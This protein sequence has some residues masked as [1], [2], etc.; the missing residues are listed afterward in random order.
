[1]AEGSDDE[2][3]KTE[4]PSQKKIDDAI[5]RGDVVKSLEVSGFFVL[6]SCMVLVAFLAQGMGRDLARPLA[7]FLEH[8][9]E[10]PVDRRGL[11]GL[12]LEA[13]KIMAIVLALPALMFLVAGIAGNM[14]QHR[15]VWSGEQ[16][17]PKLS[18]ISPLAGFKRLFSSESLMNFAKGI[19][20]IGV[21][22]GAMWMAVKPE[23][24]RLEDIVATDL[25]GLLAIT[26]HL[27]VKVMIAVL[28]VMAFVAGLD[29]FWQRRRW[30]H[31]LRMTKQEVKD[32][33]KQQ[34]GNPEIKAKIRQIRMQ[35]SRKRMM[36]EVPKSTV[37]VTNP[38]HYAVALKYE[39]GMAAPVVVAKG[40]DD[41]A[42]KIRELAKK[43]DVPV[44]ENPPL[45]RALHAAVDLDEEVP[46]EHYRAV[47]EVIGFVMRM[48]QQKK[49]WRPA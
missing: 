16:L 36:A 29:Y 40:V 42:M 14:I 23:L 43:A 19:V 6:A 24:F 34:E 45:A 15:M 1:M 12:Y 3:E 49:G 28:I 31:R 22:G 33:Y 13:G 11:V 37:V 21:V 4:E 9:H 20:K 7:A 32:E 41:I 44:V 17:V 38:T 39:Q 48:R 30:L 46:E 47:A 10:I 8:S 5:Q 2:D 26:R 27:A 18:K 25:L 35:R